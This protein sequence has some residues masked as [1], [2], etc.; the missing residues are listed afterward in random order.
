MKDILKEY[1]QHYRKQLLLSYS[2]KGD[3]ELI[4]RMIE[5]AENKLKILETNLNIR[6][7][8]I[9]V[10]I[11]I[12]Q[13]IYLHQVE[14]SL[15]DYQSFVFYLFKNK[16]GYLIVSG[17]YIAN[18][19]TEKISKWIDHF[20]SLSSLEQKKLYR[21]QLTNGKFTQQGGAG[22]GLMDIIRRSEGNINYKI[23]PADDK[24]SFFIME[25][26]VIS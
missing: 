10:L 4:A 5:L 25:V 6:K 11:E 24:H 23:I 7:R 19:K 8:V 20:S 18:K 3:D 13:N 12:L 22:L 2:G 9:H 16:T 1:M 21:K 15:V 17:N 26:K 14:F